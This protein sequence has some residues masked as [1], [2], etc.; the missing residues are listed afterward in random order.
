[1][2]RL[3]QLEAKVEEL[4]DF[5]TGHAV[6]VETMISRLAAALHSTGYWN[7]P[8]V[9][10]EAALLLDFSQAVQGVDPE[11]SSVRDSRVMDVARQTLQTLLIS[12]KTHIEQ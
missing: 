5:A 7:A 8:R 2:D 9:F 4:T 12:T 10:S 11:P 6:A 3:D 1:M